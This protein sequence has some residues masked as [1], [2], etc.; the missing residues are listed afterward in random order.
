MQALA[1]MLSDY[2]Q[3]TLYQLSEMESDMSV[4]QQPAIYP[5]TAL[6][7]NIKEV[8]EAARDSV[9]QITEN[10][11]GA[12]VFAS[13]EVLQDLIKRERED[14]AYE[15]YL[16][17]TVGRGIRDLEEGRFVTSRDE[18]FAKAAELRRSRGG[19]IDE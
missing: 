11:H 7:K 13:M 17:E 8:K 1:Q 9:V 12:Y 14:A 6:S 15:A 18:M 10:G 2:N 4:Y 19:E 5:I 16:L 3:I